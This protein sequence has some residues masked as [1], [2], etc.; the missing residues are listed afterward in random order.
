MNAITLY[1]CERDIA[2]A[3]DA[4]LDKETG[5]IATTDELENAIGQF[6]NKGADVAAYVLNLK[7]Q[8]EMIAAHEKVIASR[9]KAVGAK[10]DRL[11]DYMSF[12]MSNAGIAVIHA[13]DGTF[14]A[15]LYPNRD[16]AIEIDDGAPVDA[17][18]ARIVPESKAWDKTELKRAIK[19]GE[20][21]PSCV[22][23]VKRDRLEI[24]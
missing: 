23:L 16:E 15:M 12:C 11:H 10:I 24:K 14:S 17:R 4:A 18:F 1:Q 6:K 22:K 13:K 3:L 2:T 20:P 8:H 9:K 7:A 21:A 5:E 19:A